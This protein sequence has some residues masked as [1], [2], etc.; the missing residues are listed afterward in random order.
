MDELQI[1]AVGLTGQCDVYARAVGFHQLLSGFKKK[2]IKIN[3]IQGVC[4]RAD[5]RKEKTRPRYKDCTA[6]GLIC[7]YEE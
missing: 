5:F 1:T 4:L 7:I 6:C 3:K 2:K